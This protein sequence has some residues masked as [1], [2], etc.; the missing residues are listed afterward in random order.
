MTTLRKPRPAG[1][2]AIDVLAWPVGA[3]AAGFYAVAHASFVEDGRRQQG[4]IVTAGALCVLAAL[5]LPLKTPV[6][7]V[8]RSLAW[9]AGTTGVVLLNHLFLPAQFSYGQTKYQYLILVLALALFAVPILTFRSEL[10]TAR[11]VQSMAAVSAFYCVINLVT[12]T[13]TANVRKS[14]IELNPAVMSKICLLLALYAVAHMLVRRRPSPLHVALLLLSVAAAIKTGS[15]GPI[16]AVLISAGVVMI[17]MYG[18]SQLHRIV[19]AMLGLIVAVGVFLRFAP[20]AISDRFTLAAISVQENSGE[21]DRIDL[22]KTAFR[23]VDDN[24]N[25]I[26]MGNFL[27]YQRFVSVPHNIFLELA[28]EFGVVIAFAFL[29][30][31]LVASR[32]A[33][34]AL[35]SP[36][37]TVPVVWMGLLLLNQLANSLLGGELTLQSYLLYLPLAFFLYGIP[38][39]EPTTVPPRRRTRPT[40][41]PALSAPRRE[42]K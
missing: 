4:L 37:V 7:I 42:L 39:M 3:L 34:R 24:V 16:L 1:R 33:V 15:R 2:P 5:T 21:G 26:G 41:R 14:S 20:A 6:H 38:S 36:T 31:C 13:D 12:G 18:A 8:G 17:A 32:R 29:A 11:F 19:P 27:S 35:R 22:W 10:A 9:T 23:V 28:V 40:R 30:A 25:G